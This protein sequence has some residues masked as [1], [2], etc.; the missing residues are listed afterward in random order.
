M[1][2]SFIARRIPRQ[3]RDL[4]ALMDLY[5][6]NYLHLLQLVPEIELLEG[7]R[8]SQVA[9]A[10]DL[11]LTIL[12]RQKYTTTLS[13][14]YYFQEDGQRILEP[15]AHIRVYHDAKVVEIL[16]HQR[17]KRT[18]GRQRW[19]PE[20]RRGQLERLWRKNRFLQK[21]LGF[22]LHQGHIFFRCTPIP[23]GSPTVNGFHPLSIARTKR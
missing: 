4:A 16:H 18:V 6:N 12:E 19:R 7:T 1:H 13:L 21:W 2:E 15:N 9:G 3:V 5:E 22:C 11:Y 10:L 8:I 17:R 20:Q 14:T 23:G